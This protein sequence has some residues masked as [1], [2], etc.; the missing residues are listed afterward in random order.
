MRVICTLSSECRTHRR[1]AVVVLIFNTTEILMIFSVF[2]RLSI[3]AN[4][5]HMRM[6]FLSIYFLSTTDF[7]YVKK[8][9][10]LWLIINPSEYSERFRKIHV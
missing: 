10:H 9:H 7:F 6:A 5:V 3:C 4:P 8:V 2:L 1:D